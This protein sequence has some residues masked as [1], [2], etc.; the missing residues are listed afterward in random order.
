M[1]LFVAERNEGVEDGLWCVGDVCLFGFD[2][3]VCC[4]YT[5]E[6]CEEKCRVVGRGDIC[7]SIRESVLWSRDDLSTSCVEID[8][9]S[10]VRKTV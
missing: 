6:L 10:L 5:K 1:V 4:V 2:G 9:C 7:R 8:P 3:H